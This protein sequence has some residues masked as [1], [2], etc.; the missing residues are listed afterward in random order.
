MSNPEVTPPTTGSPLPTVTQEVMQSSVV[1][2]AQN[3]NYIRNTIDTLSEENPIL[4][5]AVCRLVE[6]YGQ[7][8]G[9]RREQL[10]MVAAVVYNALR[11]QAQTNALN[12]QLM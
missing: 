4:L 8:D 10:Y 7:E 6:V 1:D 2:I 11:N 12:Q 3:P 9:A 5:D